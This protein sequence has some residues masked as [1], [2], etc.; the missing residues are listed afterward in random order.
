EVEVPTQPQAPA[1]PAGV[2]ASVRSDGA[3]ALAWD[4][5]EGAEGYDVYRGI[6]A[7]AQLT[8]DPING[9][10]LLTTTATIDLDVQPGATYHYLVVAVGAGGETP[11]AAQAVV[12]TPPA[13]PACAPGEWAAEYFD[14]RE[15]QGGVVSRECLPAVDKNWYNTGGPAGLGHSDFSA[16]FTTTINEGAGTYEF[17]AQADD[18]VRVYVDG[19]RVINQWGPGSWNT[20]YTA[21]VELTAGEHEIVVEYFEAAGAARIT[22]DYFKVDSGEPPACPPGEW[23]AEY[24]DG[25]ELQGR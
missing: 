8:D 25:R 12:T 7:P 17:Q 9:A 24:F 22:F 19:Q 2:T 11:A 16:R 3:V 14:G 4:P 15:L 5:A 1:A 23:A 10:A 13:A 20:L 18:G 6:G 21:E